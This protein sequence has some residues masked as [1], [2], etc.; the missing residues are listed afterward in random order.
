MELREKREQFTH[1]SCFHLISSLVYVDVTSSW[2][3]PAAPPLCSSPLAPFCLTHH[4]L[5]PLKLNIFCVISTFCNPLHPDFDLLLS[6]FAPTPFAPCLPCLL[7]L[8]L[9]LLLVPS[10]LIFPPISPQICTRVSSQGR[11]LPYLLTCSL[12]SQ[13]ICILPPPPP[14]PPPAPPPS[15]SN[16][17]LLGCCVVC[18]VTFGLLQ[19]I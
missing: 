5:T 14:A 8:L 4:G 17:P 2:G 6:C 12:L 9:L 13:V 16:R 3:G 18:F 1:L 15:V 11:R 19:Y 10:P 7:L